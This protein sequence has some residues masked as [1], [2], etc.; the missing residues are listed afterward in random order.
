MG[1]PLRRSSATRLSRVPDAGGERTT[2]CAGPAS[3]SLKPA[4]VGLAIAP[5][6]N[7]SSNRCT[8]A[9]NCRRGDR[10]GSER[11]RRVIRSNVSFGSPASPKLPFCWQTKYEGPIHA[12]LLWTHYNDT[13]LADR[14]RRR[15]AE[16]AST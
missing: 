3:G 13:G 6:G 12:G 15:Q 5:V 8:F 10:F 4:R 14:E 11:W 9:F 7:A 16:T 1:C 2:S